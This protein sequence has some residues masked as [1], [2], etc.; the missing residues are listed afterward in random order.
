[1]RAC[2]AIE[3]G[4]HGLFFRR[5]PRPDRTQVFL[6]A[7]GLTTL[8]EVGGKLRRDRVGLR[9]LDTDPR[10]LPPIADE[11]SRERLPGCSRRYR[12]RLGQRLPLRK[13]IAFDQVPHGPLPPVGP[14]SLYRALMTRR[15]ATPTSTAKSRVVMLTARP[16]RSRSSATTPPRRSWPRGAGRTATEHRGRPSCL[17]STCRRHRC[18]RRRRGRC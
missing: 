5:S 18:P 10:S 14:D 7:C 11:P 3:C 15:L 9:R 1:M 4:G 13:P 12:R 6:L 16:A 17:K 8:G 2:L